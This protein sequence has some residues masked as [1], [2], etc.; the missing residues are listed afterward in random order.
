MVQNG[1]IAALKVNFIAA[2]AER[3]PQNSNGKNVDSR[4]ERTSEL[5]SER[6][7]GPLGN[8]HFGMNVKDGFGQ[9]QPLDF[10]QSHGV[11]THAANT[12]LTLMNLMQISP[13]K[14]KAPIKS[15]MDMMGHNR[16]Y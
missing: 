6:L 11:Y 3:L 9:M 4:F 14:P 8:L 10:W 7:G 13:Y 16:I 1:H 5:K 15:E 2:R 12:R